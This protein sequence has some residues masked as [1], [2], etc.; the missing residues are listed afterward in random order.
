MGVDLDAEEL[1]DRSQDA[2]ERA[3]HS[4]WLERLARAGL[5]ARGLLYGVVAVLALRVAQGHRELQ[6]DK[7]GALR[8]V[9][10]QPMGRVLVLLLAVGFAG[11]ALW[12]FVEAAVGPPDERDRRKANFKR[13]GYAARGVLYSVFFVSAVK[14]FIWST[15]AAADDNAEADWTARVLNWPGGTWLVQI[16]GLAVIGAGLYIGWRGISGKFRRRL[17]SLEMGPAVRHWVRGVGTVG[18]VA[19]MLVTVLIGVFLIAAA[20]QHDPGQAVG[21][22]G[23]LKRLADHPFGPVL[24]VLVAA[25]LGAY[26]VYSLAEARYRRVAGH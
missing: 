7:Q 21:I 10:R 5:V 14:L 22:D 11:Y 19:R 6:P 13:I 15:R 16:V 23:A 17:K 1:K 8:T 3:A 18:M 12:R 24:L 4:T 26:G 25:G 20:R 2:L 9:V